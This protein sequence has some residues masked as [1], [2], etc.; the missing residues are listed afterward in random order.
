MRAQFI[1]EEFTEDSDPIK[2]MGIGNPEKSIFPALAKELAKYDIEIVWC[3]DNELGEGFW[4]FNIDFN[5]YEE[6]DELYIQLSYAT[7]EAAE[8]EFSEEGWKGGFSLFDEDG[9][10]SFDKATH[11]IHKVVKELVYQKY[12]DKP[13]IQQKIKRMEKDLI[14]L[15]NVEKIL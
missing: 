12:G 4:N 15:K 10:M 9:E 5:D 1:N 8:R 11:D 6:F 2:D 13:D 14:I 7:D 3:E